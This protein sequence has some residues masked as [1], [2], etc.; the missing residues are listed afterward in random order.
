MDGLDYDVVVC[1]ADIMD[2]NVLSVL[3]DRLECWQAQ[4]K[5]ADWITPNSLATVRVI[6]EDESDGFENRNVFPYRDEDSTD[7]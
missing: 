5:G 4:R 7:S 3:N 6:T 2:N 1:V